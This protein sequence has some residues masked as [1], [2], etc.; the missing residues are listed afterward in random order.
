[1]QRRVYHDTGV[2]DGRTVRPSHATPP[3]PP[4][5][6][7][8]RDVPISLTLPVGV[9]RSCR[10]DDNRLVEHAPRA[11]SFSALLFF[12]WSCC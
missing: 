8:F 4:R 6:R 1:M 9:P 11:L 12:F 3:L 5:F 7:A 2:S 10:G